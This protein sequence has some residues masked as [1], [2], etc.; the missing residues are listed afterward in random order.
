MNPNVIVVEI[1]AYLLQDNYLNR[2][3]PYFRNIITDPQYFDTCKTL[4][5]I[6]INFTCSNYAEEE[7]VMESTQAST[8]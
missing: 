3:K 5:T 8:I 6:A 7:R 4:L 2:T 1:E